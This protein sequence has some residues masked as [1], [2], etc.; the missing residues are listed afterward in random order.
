MAPKFRMAVKHG[1]TE[2]V[3]RLVLAVP[4]S[5]YAT[6][7]GGS[8]LHVARAAVA[9]ASQPAAGAAGALSA[10]T[11]WS[12]QS[13]DRTGG[14][15]LPPR[16]DGR[17]EQ[18][19]RIMGRAARP[20]AAAAAAVERAVI[21][22]TAAADEHR[23]RRAPA[24]GWCAGARPD[25]CAG[26]SDGDPDPRRS[27]R[28][29]ARCEAAELLP[30]SVAAA[31]CR[32]CAL[33]VKTRTTHRACCWPLL[34]VIKIEHPTRGDDTR[35]WGPPFSEDGEAAY[36]IAVNRNKRSVTVNIA[37]PVP[38]TAHQRCLR[39]PPTAPHDGLSDC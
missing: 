29:R 26:R 23:C 38:R 36:F 7:A 4:W 15:P 33:H 9:R 27:W 19:H 1:C 37:D 28:R 14:T 22:A 35:S 24:A 11:R 2:R 6:H 30:P 21:A 16:R 25:P 13:T 5:M 34:Q 10:A 17:A 32:T 31:A 12:A 18:P 20:D 8:N 39:T 3:R